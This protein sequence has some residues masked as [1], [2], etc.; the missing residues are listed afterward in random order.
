MAAAI[1]NQG[2]QAIRDALKTL[3]T[4]VGLSTDA[5]AFVATQT[6]INPSGSGTNIIKAATDTDVAFDTADSTITVTSADGTGNFATISVLNG[7]GA[8][9]ALTRFV[10]S[11]TIGI[12]AGDTY[13]IAVRYQ[14]T[15]A[16]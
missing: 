8:S 11:A 2:K 6:A 4:H 3:V 13:T 5:T 16:T 10:R 12:Q 14:V 1:L 15:D 7:S 9:A